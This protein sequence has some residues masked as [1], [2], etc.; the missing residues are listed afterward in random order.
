MANIQNSRLNTLLTRPATTSQR[1][2]NPHIYFINR[3]GVVY[4]RLVYKGERLMKSTGVSC[5]VGAFNAA[6]LKVPGNPQY[7]QLLQKLRTQANQLFTELRLTNRPV[8]LGQIWNALLS[9]RFF[10]PQVPPLAAILTEFEEIIHREYVVG[11]ITRTTANRAKSCHS[12]IAAFIAKQ[13]GSHARIEQIVPADARALETFMKLNY[14]HSHNYAQ[15]TVQH[16]KRIL[17]YAV[18]K[19]WITRNPF[20]NFQRK[21]DIKKGE[22]LTEAELGQPEQATLFSPVLDRIRDVFVFMCWTGLSYK[23]TQQLRPEHIKQTTDG[24]FYIFK[25]RQKTG[26]GSYPYLTERCLDIL[27]K[28]STDPFCQQRGQL[29]PIPANA[30][31]NGYLKQVIGITG[32]TKSVSC[33]TARRTYA[34]ILQAKGVEEQYITSAMGHKDIAI[35]NRHYIHTQPEPIIRALKL[36]LG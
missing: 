16:L 19:E 24:D 10:S 6:T 11:D 23:D 1:M 29:L 27:K 12:Q 28:Y 31:I 3:K 5:P 13:Y 26:T 8:D 34:T 7:S 36:K 33:H 35:T 2:A 4:C 14:Q 18:E 22:Y 30:K 15:K 9:N 21:I 25:N 32:I 20:L 17:N